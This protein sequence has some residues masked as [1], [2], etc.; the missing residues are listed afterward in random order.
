[1]T[2]YEAQKEHLE[3]EVMKLEGKIA[4]ITGGT[5][6]I[7]RATANLLAKKGVKVFI[8]GR[9]EQDLQDAL[10]DLGET[11]GEYHGLNADQAYEDQV[12]HVF[13]ETR[14]VF[15][16]P[17]VLINNAALPA[18][19]ILGTSYDDALYILRT[20]LLGYLMCIR[21]AVKGMRAKGG[22]HIVN[23]GSMSAKVREAGSDIY[24]A[25]KAGIEGL[26]ESLRKQL[27]KENIRV[28]LIEPGLVGT[29]LHGDPADVHR[30]L[31]ME[32]EGKMLEAEDI[33]QAVYCVLTY[34]PRSNVYEVRV[35]P[36]K[37]AI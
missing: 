22:G 28:S 8:Y 34:P 30:Q 3:P 16:D 9:D 15:G 4:L 33:A 29:D 20:N 36:V 37:Q 18:A 32:V 19:S 1:M 35:G 21:E 23:I 6:G 26:S 11:G 27:G 31:Q 17:D 13:D 25:T 12:L 10:H 24:V 5:T 2:T 7:G 14:R